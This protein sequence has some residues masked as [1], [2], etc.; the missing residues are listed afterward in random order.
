VPLRS[1]SRPVPPLLYPSNQGQNK[2]RSYL[3][4]LAV[5]ACAGCGP[6]ARGNLVPPPPA[7]R[8]GHGAP[9]YDPHVN[10]PR[11]ERSPYTRPLPPTKEKGLWATHP[12]DDDA[13]SRP[14]L[15]GVELPYPPTATTQAERETTQL[16]AGIMGGF[17]EEHDAYSHA[18]KVWAEPLRRCAAAQLYLKC[19]EGYQDLYRQHV[20]TGDYMDKEYERRLKATRE[21]AERFR[22]EAC[23]GMTLPPDAEEFVLA[24]GKLWEKDV[25]RQANRGR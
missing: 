24:T 25:S 3:A 17:A 10:P 7:L 6:S 19:V 9:T 23:R 15:L 16:C 21:N 1:C 8:P 4:T 20:R 5:L 11:P 14:L 12:S 2:M 22:A 13:P 18:R